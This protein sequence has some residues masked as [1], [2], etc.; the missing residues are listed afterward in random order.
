[1]EYLLHKREN[2]MNADTNLH[3]TVPSGMCTLNSYHV[4]W[5]V[6]WSRTDR[7]LVKFDESDSTTTNM[8]TPPYYC[9][10]SIGL[11]TGLRLPWT[12]P[13]EDRLIQ[14]SRNY[15][16]WSLVYYDAAQGE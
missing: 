7:V 8:L 12:D 4:S 1:M 3:V 2:E 6:W 15:S 11:A 13:T 9:Q 10:P 14:C 16:A 5:V